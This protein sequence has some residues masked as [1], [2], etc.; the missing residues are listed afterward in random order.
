MKI[1]LSRPGSP[2][3]HL[4]LKTLTNPGATLGD[5]RPVSFI[6]PGGPGAD[7]MAYLDYACLHEITDLVFHDPRGCGKSDKTHPSHYTMHN[8]IDDV[9]DIRKYLGLNKIIVIGKSYGSMCAL[10]YA[11]KYPQA[12]D[13]LILAAGAPSYRFIETAKKNL[14]RQASSEQIAICE[15]LW[16]GS[17]S[18]PEELSTFFRLTHSLYSFKARTATHEFDANKKILRFSYDVLNEGFRHAFWHFDYE[19]ILQKI[20]CP[21]L[22]LAGR[23]DWINDIEHAEFMVA[24]IPHS[25]LNIFEQASHA[26]EVDMPSEFFQTIADFIQR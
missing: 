9:E 19:N 21:T 15:K 26:M 17:F 13:K 23:H 8:Y 22:I 11:L 1:C 4:F 16:S 25:Q 12:V 5:R 7:H 6:L 10:G 20:L 2:Q 14:Q 18:C 24:R 3:T